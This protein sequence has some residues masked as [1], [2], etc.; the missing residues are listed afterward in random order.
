MKTM[1]MVLAVLA[2]A[3]SAAVLA[4]QHDHDA[5]VPREELPAHTHTTGAEDCHYHD[6]DGRPV[7]PEPDQVVLVGS[8]CIV[9]GI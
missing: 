5:A 3:G 9:L 1:M 4:G 8:S 7:A 6:E 2:M